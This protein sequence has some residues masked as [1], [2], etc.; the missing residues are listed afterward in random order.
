MDTFKEDIGA[1]LL[2]EHGQYWRPVAYVSWALTQIKCQY[3]QIEK[4]ALVLVHGCRKFHLFIYGRPVLAEADHKPL[5]GIAERV[6][7]NTAQR[8]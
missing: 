2:Q 1:V 8:V 5:I 7:A 6:L 4:E 3:A